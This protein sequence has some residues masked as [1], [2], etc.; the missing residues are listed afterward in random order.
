[1]ATA[2]TVAYREL[3]ACIL[4]GRLEP[5]GK[6]VQKK[7]A[8]AMGLS[9]TPVA[10]ALKRLEAEHLVRSETGRGFFVSQCGT[11]DLV[12]IYMIRE[13][14]EPIA[15]RQ[16]AYTADRPFIEKLRGL[17]TPFDPPIRRDAWPDYLEA[18]REFHRLIVAECGNPYLIQAMENCR[19][20]AQVYSQALTM[21]PSQ[22]YPQHLA[23]IEAVDVGDP[24]AAENA[25][26]QHMVAS[27][28]S[29]VE[30]LQVPF[31]AQT[32]AFPR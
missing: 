30:R 26:R 25:M 16:V 4:D 12:A 31:G 32:A 22:S 19:V 21:P 9:R 5:G 17:F 3:K 29:F 23:I 14:L 7:F 13:G 28:R 2:D 18:D 10:L 6:V 11:E 27:Y 8:E 20:L 15:A 24:D 1:M